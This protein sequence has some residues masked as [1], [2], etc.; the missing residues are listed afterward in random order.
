VQE[1]NEPKNRDTRDTSGIF[2][3]CYAAD[4]MMQFAKVYLFASDYGL[5]GIR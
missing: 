1:E 3:V 5:Q 2:N 4:Y